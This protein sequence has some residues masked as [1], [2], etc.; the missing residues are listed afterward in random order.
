MVS[1]LIVMVV[2]AILSSSLAWSFVEIP[3]PANEAN[4]KTHGFGSCLTPPKRVLPFIRVDLGFSAT[5]LARGLPTVKLYESVLSAGVVGGL[6][7][8]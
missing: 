3:Q 7:L 2:W 6:F 5:Y 4:E 1:V 8:R